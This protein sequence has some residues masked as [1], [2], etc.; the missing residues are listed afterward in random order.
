MICERSGRTAAIRTEVWRGAK[1]RERERSVRPPTAKST[2]PWREQRAEATE[3]QEDNPR[4]RRE[5]RK[6]AFAKV[7]AVL[8]FARQSQRID[9][10]N[11]SDVRTRRM[12]D[13]G[14]CRLLH[15]QSHPATAQ[16][17]EAGDTKRQQR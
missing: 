1:A 3:R 14:H 17:R 6:T 9:I 8:S 4:R 15:S 16:T 11:K 7:V 12:S 13:G 5:R 10:G 2:S